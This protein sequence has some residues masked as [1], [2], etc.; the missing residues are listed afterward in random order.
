MKYKPINEMISQNIRFLRL[1]KEWSQ[2][3]MAKELN[4]SITA[5]SKIETGLT[6]INLSRLE[7]IAE[8][9]DITV[10]QLAS[11]LQ[12]KLPPPEMGMPEIEQKLQL[13]QTEACGL[14]NRIIE[15][16]NQLYDLDLASPR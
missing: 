4:I 15:L 2:A 13:C 9:F 6:D 3:K 12:A 1:K 10:A 14:R 11:D 16:Y 8:L 5:V 7:Q